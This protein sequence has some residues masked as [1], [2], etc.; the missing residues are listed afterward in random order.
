MSQFSK[1]NSDPKIGYMKAVKK[2]VRYLKNTMY[3]GLV[4]GA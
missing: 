2:V 1:H 4:Y 3:L